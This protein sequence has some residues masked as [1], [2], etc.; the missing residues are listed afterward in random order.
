MNIAYQLG[1]TFGGLAFVF[2]FIG[3]GMNMVQEETDI[4]DAQIGGF[5]LAAGIM[6]ILAVLSGVI[7]IWL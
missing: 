1:V 4:S 5:I 3:F 7:G 6:V 2:L